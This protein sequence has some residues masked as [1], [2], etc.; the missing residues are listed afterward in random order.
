MKHDKTL[1]A[2]VDEKTMQN[3]V[4]IKK[5]LRL[6]SGAEAVRRS[7]AIA[8]ILIS[9]LKKGDKIMLVS[10]NGAKRELMID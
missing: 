3:I 5:S 1:I 10:K 9:A 6:H 8:K 2:R 4:D 7:V